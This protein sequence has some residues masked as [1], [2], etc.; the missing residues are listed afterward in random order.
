MAFKALLKVQELQWAG[1]TALFVFASACTSPATLRQQAP[2]RPAVALP[3]STIA[4][5]PS[6]PPS[7]P[8]V[9][10]L[11]EETEQ[12]AMKMLP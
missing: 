8:R 7:E 9:I 11:A 10:G 1:A 12:N 4:P 3:Q 5:A 6:P 2:A